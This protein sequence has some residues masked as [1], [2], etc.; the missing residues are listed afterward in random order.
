MSSKTTIRIDEESM[1]VVQKPTVLT[2]PFNARMDIATHQLIQEFRREAT[3]RL[4]N[5]DLC[6][7]F[8][9]E[10]L[11]RLP[12]Q[13]P[14]ASLIIEQTLTFKTAIGQFK[15][16]MKLMLYLGFIVKGETLSLPSILLTELQAKWVQCERA[17]IDTRY[18]SY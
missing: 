9:R 18:Q 16:G 8:L 1:F 17:E 14:L 3:L 4:V 7:A 5:F 13:L 15:A 12:M 6:W 10:T 2:L 11:L